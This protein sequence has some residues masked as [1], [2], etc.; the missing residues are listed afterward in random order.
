MN[1][2]CT[3]LLNRLYARKR[4]ELKARKNLNNVEIEEERV[5]DRSVDDLLLFINSGNEGERIIRRNLLQTLK[6]GIIRR[7]VAKLHAGRSGSFPL[8]N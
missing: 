2:P 5:D 7:L 3:G 6:I 4:K 8:F 1:D